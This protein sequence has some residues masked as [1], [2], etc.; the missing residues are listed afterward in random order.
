MSYY[1]FILHPATYNLLVPR[2]R[3]LNQAL[4]HN[5][6]KL[7]RITEDGLENGKNFFSLDYYEDAICFLRKQAF[8][9]VFNNVLL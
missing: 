1:E 3:E 9:A 4:N 6:C 7:G 5:L 8:N 2:Y